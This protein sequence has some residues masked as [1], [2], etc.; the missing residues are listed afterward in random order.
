VIVDNMAP[1]VSLSPVPPL[2]RGL[3]PLS[4]AASTDTTSVLF[5]IRPQAGSWADLVTDSAAPYTALVDT[6]ALTDG[7]YVFRAVATDAAGHTTP[8]L[9]AD[10]L[11]D[12][13]APS[14][15]LL[16][17][18]SGDS[19]SSNVVHLVAAAFDAGS[20]IVSVTFQQRSSGGA[21]ADLATAST[22]PYEADWDRTSFPAGAYD[23]RAILLDTAGNNFATPPTT[24]TLVAAALPPPPPPTPF[25]FSAGKVKLSA[26]SGR[27]FLG[28]PVKLSRGASVHSSLLSGKKTMRK[29]LNKLPAGE[30]T[31]K[32]GIAR[33]LLKKGTYTLVLTAI[34]ADGSRVQRR[35][36][37]RVPAK[38]RVATRR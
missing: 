13:T 35:L 1:T 32:L 38:I 14:G 3:L 36:V 10:V 30:P 2:A 31:L 21:W 20:G 26:R 18:G 5:Q 6:T 23:V 27:A 4:A 28:L 16:L 12:N 33:R 24:I 19:V 9:A 37:V 11:V 29:W 22:A 15:S 17:P 25:T 7:N 8:S 34:A